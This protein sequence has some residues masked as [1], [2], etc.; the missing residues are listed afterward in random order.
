MVVQQ[1]RRRRSLLYVTFEALRRNGKDEGVREVVE[2]RGQRKR[3][4]VKGKGLGF[5]R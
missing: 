4:G 5:K 1:L 3:G 2:E